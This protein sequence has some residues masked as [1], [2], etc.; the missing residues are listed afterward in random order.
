MADT[1]IVESEHHNFFTLTFAHLFTVCDWLD[2]KALADGENDELRQV[3]AEIKT[4][5]GGI[6]KSSA[7]P[8]HF[9]IQKEKMEKLSNLLKRAVP[10]IQTA[11]FKPGFDQN[12]AKFSSVIANH[13]SA[14]EVINQGAR[15]IVDS[16]AKPAE[17]NIFRKFFDNLLNFFK[18][19]G[20]RLAHKQE[21]SA[22][23]THVNT[24]RTTA[25]LS[26]NPRHS[27]SNPLPVPPQP[28]TQASRT[29]SQQVTGAR[30][31]GV[32]NEDLQ[33]SHVFKKAQQKHSSGIT[34]RTQP[35]AVAPRR[36][37]SPANTD[38]RKVG[39]QEVPANPPTQQVAKKPAIPVAPPPPPVKHK[40]KDQAGV[41]HYKAA[42]HKIHL[43]EKYDKNAQQNAPAPKDPKHLEEIRKG[44]TL[45]KVDPS[46][47]QPAKKDP[48]PGFQGQLEEAMGQRRAQIVQ[49]ESK[50]KEKLRDSSEWVDSPR[51]SRKPSKK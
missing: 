16:Q 42:A 41:Q 40:E 33:Q 5:Q 18:A 1:F 6:I 51:N 31:T 27:A 23:Q 17:K 30:S 34:L 47:N 37:S 13:S 19:F 15:L 38:D 45:K 22:V 24:P 7:K 12:I 35:P 44:V 20:K 48:S 21:A 9:E 50:N 14:I 8:K 32:R 49:K 3:L 28:P 4:L 29:A 46:K 26:E 25:P 36:F 11:T 10:L 2:K 39:K 43:W